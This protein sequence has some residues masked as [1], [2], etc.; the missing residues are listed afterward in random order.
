MVLLS[1]GSHHLVLNCL[2]FADM[3]MT[4]HSGLSH[5]QNLLHRR[6]TVVDAYV[7]AL[8]VHFKRIC[9]F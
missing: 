9:L 3:L 4:S 6:Q 7:D 5:C 2:S 1:F 8:F